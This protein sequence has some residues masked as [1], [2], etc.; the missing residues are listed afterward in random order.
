MTT[1]S[2]PFRA[3]R[4]A[5]LTPAGPVPTTTTS[6]F[7]TTGTFVSGTV[8]NSVFLASYLFNVLMI[9]TPPCRL[10][11]LSHFLILCSSQSRRKTKYVMSSFTM[12]LAL[13]VSG[14]PLSPLPHI[15]LGSLLW[16]TPSPRRIGQ[17]VHFL[18]WRSVPLARYARSVL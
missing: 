13:S 8:I 17:V 16:L 7:I 3:A 14:W 1:V 2:A 10:Y 5:A 15:P 12:G 18:R 6:A 9:L 11:L 4:T